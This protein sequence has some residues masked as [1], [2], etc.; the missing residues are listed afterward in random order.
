MVASSK[1]R[2]R[3]RRSLL[4]LFLAPTTLEAPPYIFCQ[5]KNKHAAIRHLRH[6][7]TNQ[8]W[9]IT[10]R[11]SGTGN[12]CDIFGRLSRS[13]GTQRFPAEHTVSSS[14]S[15][16]TS[17]SVECSRCTNGCAGSTYGLQVSFPQGLFICLGQMP[18]FHYLH[19]VWE[20]PSSLHNVYTRSILP[21][22]ALFYQAIVTRPIIPAECRIGYRA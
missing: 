21:P 16:S 18:P 22:Y 4:K 2:L 5:Q 20:Y 9:W 7:A 19:L 14:I 17:S 12:F 10:S 11:S 13:S 1:A 3:A 8:W 6:E 15:G